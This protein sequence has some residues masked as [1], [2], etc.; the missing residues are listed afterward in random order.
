M[1]TL[2]WRPGTPGTVGVRSHAGPLTAGLAVAAVAELLILRTFT[3]T[4]IHIP[5]LEAMQGPYE[6]LA[7]MGR[8]AYFLSVAL[9]LL[10]LPV[11]AW[12][13][14][15]DQRP[16]R[17][18]AASAV[19]LFL[20][21]SGAAAAGLGGRVTLDLA[22]LLAVVSLA[23]LAAGGWRL[24]GALPFGMLAVAFISS[25]GYTVLQTASQEGGGSIHASWLLSVG[26]LSGAA[27]ALSLPLLARRRVDRPSVV[28]G[29]AVGVVA[30]AMFVGGGE[31]TSRILLLWNAGLSG[32]LPGT[33]YAAGAGALA[34]TFVALLRG[35]EMLAAMAVALLVTGGLGL[36]NTYQTGLV[37]AGLAALCLA[38][39]GASR[40]E[41]GREEAEDRD[42]SAVHRSGVG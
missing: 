7:F 33:V 39:G 22:S 12:S 6:V 38:A 1:A 29:V 17:R 24:S 9:L 19:G 10:A 4:A 30:F 14:A 35:R 31:T 5:A 13:L 21:T 25:G 42:A 41:Q 36:H 28:V 32:T 11:L 40:D 8:Y 34:L 26:E 18:V 20:L 27:F 37:V 15:L 3:R 2:R 23:G 16:G